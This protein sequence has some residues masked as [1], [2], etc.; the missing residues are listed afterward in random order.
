M[1][2]LQ[3]ILLTSAAILVATTSIQAAKPEPLL[4]T[5][6]VLPFTSQ[7]E[8][9]AGQ[10][11]SLAFLLEAKLATETTL[12]LVERAE[13]D[14]LLSE[15]EAA[16]SGTVD[17]QS[18]AK[19]G[20]LTGAKL[21]ITGRCIPADSATLVVAKVIGTENGRMFAVKKSVPQGTDERPMDELGAELAKLIA[22]NAKE[23]IPI[24]ESAEQR[25]ERLKKLLPAGK[26]LPSVHVSVAEE[27]L[28][29]RIPD[30]AVQTEI[31]HTLQA[32]GFK[33]VDQADKADW[34][35]TGEAFS[36]RGL[37]RGN[38]ITCRAR[39]EIKSQRAGE[40]TV[41]VDRQTSAAVDLAENVAGKSALQNAGS[42]LAERLVTM[43]AK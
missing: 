2:T 38:L 37:Q 8:A 12:C 3:P 43:L 34:R 39:A 13:I 20:H 32:L 22:D 10:A 1:K 26:P 23:L 41:K 4:L 33:L 15:Q 24:V 16:L 29:G 42:A 35:V 9:Q 7:E 36:E 18:A 27:H 14:K 5:A 21:V 11:K 30:P 28:A 40:S 19:V 6:A 31:Q 17:A 25:I